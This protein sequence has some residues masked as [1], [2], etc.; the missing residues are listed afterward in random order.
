MLP[1][2]LGGVVPSLAVN[3]N[4]T[5]VGLVPHGVNRAFGCTV[6]VSVETCRARRTGMVA[7]GI[8]WFC[9]PTSGTE[10]TTSGLRLFPS[11]SIQV[12]R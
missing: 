3:M 7:L 4:S 2:C 12:F 10:S 1:T 5:V 9:S 6:V 8:Y 11:M